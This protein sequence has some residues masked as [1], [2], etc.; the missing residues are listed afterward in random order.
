MTLPL[1]GWLVLAGYLV[2]ITSFGA[3]LGRK[4]GSIEDYF[5]ASHR[6]PWWAITACIV[7]TETSTLTFT[8][9]P[10]FA[11]AGNWGFL[12]L[13][14]GYILGRVLAAFVLI[15]AY[16]RGQLYTS[17]EFLLRRFG[18]SVRSVAAAVFLLS[19]TVADGVR[20]HAAAL[21]VSVAAGVPEYA[22]ILV[23]AFAMILYTE[24]G[25]VKATI[26]T[27][28]VQLFVYLAGAVWILVAVTRALPGGAGPALSQAYAQGKLAVFDFEL[29]LSRAY[30]FWAGIVGG[31][32][33]TLATHGTDHY[34]VQRLLVAPSARQAGRGLMASGLIVF[35]QFTLFLLIGTLLWAFYGGRAFAR[36]DEVV[37][38]FVGQ[39]LTGAGTGFILAAVV[40]AAL[41]PSL[42]S[43]ASSTLR[44]FYLPYVNP[45]AS[46][47]LQIRMGRFFTV[48]W[49]VAQ[50][51]VALSA[52]R[53]QSSLEAG[54][55]ALSY[56]SGPT[57][58]AFFLGVLT[59]RASA[60][61]TLAGMLLGL[62]APYVVGLWT[63]LA[64]TWNVAVGATVTF[65]AGYVLSCF[66]RWWGTGAFI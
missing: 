29:D 3:Y 52:Q 4:R 45:R 37:P 53:I 28:V 61:G 46:E 44:D 30:T 14:I 54:L 59:R 39:E 9:V 22:C 1:S 18:P 23:L 56:A 7:A 8:S 12:Q 27:D 41:S 50:V 26:W 40:A 48:S 15:P 35:A 2:A 21:V 10:G 19:R 34:I 49:G 60:R 57:V 62:V 17:Y 58:G 36:G 38:T 65:V 13:V 5:L 43:M 20:L 51:G 16:F 64:F 31:V 55:T 32:F 63:P 42:N 33:L 11:Y 25:G 6:I 24:E 66:S 47:A